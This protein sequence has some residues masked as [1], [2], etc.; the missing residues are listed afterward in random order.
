MKLTESIH[1]VGSGSGGIGLTSPYDCNVYYIDCGTEGILIDAGSG[2][3]QELVTQQIAEAGGEKKPITKIFLTHHHA[4]HAGGAAGLRA[5]YQC[6]VYAPDW[7]AD[8][9][10]TADE[11]ELGLD[12]AKR[13]GFYP[14]DYRFSPCPVDQRVQPGDIFQ[15]GSYTLIVYDGAG[16]S[17]GGVCYE[18]AIDGKDV[19][20]V[21]DLVAYGGLI[22]LQNIPGADVARYSK[23]VLGLEEIPVDCFL[24]GHGCFSLSGGDAHVARAAAE[25]KKLG[26]PKNAI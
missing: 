3:S 12:V 1:M 17:R 9:I 6:Q 23:S 18:L 15:V 4:D 19:L 16:H 13:A 5:H 2:C 11:E 22:S 24:P 8:S 21:G 10:I 25:F 14:M 26:I 7:E 20:F